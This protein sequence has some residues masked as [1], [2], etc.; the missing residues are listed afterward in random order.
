MVWFLRIFLEGNSAS[1][2]TV[3]YRTGSLLFAETASYKYTG[4]LCG[5]WEHEHSCT[6]TGKQFRL[7]KIFLSDS[8]S[9][10]RIIKNHFI[11]IKNTKNL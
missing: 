6:G 7:K 2:V 10:T 5:I 3:P 1:E 8:I 4:N 11:K 9:L